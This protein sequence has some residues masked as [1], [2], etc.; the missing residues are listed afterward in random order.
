MTDALEADMLSGA[1]AA[2]R[3]RAARQRE[4]AARW[5]VH[6]DGGVVVKAGEGAIAE[7]IAA[8]LDQAADEFEREAR[9][10]GGLGDIRDRHGPA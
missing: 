6:G 10:P 4:V 8:A 2:L 5:T 9:R 3:R 7:R 1:I